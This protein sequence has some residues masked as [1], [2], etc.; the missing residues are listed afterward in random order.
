LR[1]LVGKNSFVW[2][3]TEN[4]PGLNFYGLLPNVGAVN[5]RSWPNARDKE[6]VG[7]TATHRSDRQAA[8]SDM[9]RDV[10]QVMHLLEDTSSPQH[11]RNE[12]HITYPPYVWNSRIEAWGAKN[13]AYLNYTPDILDWYGDGFRKL[14]DFWDRHLYNGNA[15]V[16]DAAENGGTSTLGLAEWCNG[17]FLGE[18]H[19]YPEYFDMLERDGSKNVKWYPFPSRD[20]ST[21]YAQ[22]IANLPSAIQ[23]LNLKN[24]YQGQAIY[25]NKTGDGLIYTDISRFTYFAAKC[26]YGMMTINDDNVLLSFHTHPTGFLKKVLEQF[27]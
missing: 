20:R 2:S 10:G 15:T 24:G 25:I 22:A 11:V 17:N 23:S 21:D 7:F 12:Q 19:L 8:L 13:A 1:I 5:V 4:C 9:F 6:G 26:S 18:R 27:V 16:L 3:S 14:E